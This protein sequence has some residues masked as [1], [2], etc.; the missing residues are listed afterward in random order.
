[1]FAREHATKLAQPCHVVSA[2]NVV[3]NEHDNHYHHAEHEQRAD[4]IVNEFCPACQGGKGARTQPW[5]Q[6]VLAK[7]QGQSG[8]R[9]QDKA[10][11]HRPVRN[12]FCA[13]KALEQASTERAVQFDLAFDDK[14]QQQYNRYDED[15]NPGVE[16]QWAVTQAA[17]VATGTFN[18][19][20]CFSPWYGSV[21][22]FLFDVRPFWRDIPAGF[23]G[24]SG[25]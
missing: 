19:H 9:E 15:A 20:V 1:M 3:A 12:T 25:R 6:Y 2:P 23:R 14:K 10:D 8:Q 7:Q 11:R 13:V 4:K 17:P 21:L 24:A 18:Q 22:R 5:H 16:G